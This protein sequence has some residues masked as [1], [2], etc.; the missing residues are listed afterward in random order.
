MTFSLSLSQTRRTAR[1]KRLGNGTTLMTAT[2]QRLPRASSWLVVTCIACLSESYIL[3]TQGDSF[4]HRLLLPMCCSTV[5]ALK[6]DQPTSLIAPSANPLQMKFV[7]R[8]PSS[9]P[10]VSLLLRRERR[11][12]CS[13]RRR[14]D[15]RENAPEM[16]YIGPS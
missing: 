14:E 12:R 10:A 4:P 2:S 3:Y 1:T 11:R 5:A 8:K 16:R 7:F 15:R 9:V 6:A 13:V